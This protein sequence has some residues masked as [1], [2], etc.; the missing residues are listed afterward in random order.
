LPADM[1]A[2]LHKRLVAQ[3]RGERPEKPLNSTEAALAQVA[4]D[5]IPKSLR[6]TKH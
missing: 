1:L 4:D 2:E 5:G 6:R 3:Y